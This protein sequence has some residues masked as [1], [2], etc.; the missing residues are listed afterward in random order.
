LAQRSLAG[1]ASDEMAGDEAIA[2]A[3]RLSSCDREASIQHP[4]VAGLLD[5]SCAAALEEMALTQ[6][7]VLLK[8]QESALWLRG[9][10]HMI[11]LQQ[12]QETVWAQLR[13]LASLQDTM[14]QEQ[15][16][17]NSTMLDLASKIDLAVE[18]GE[19]STVGVGASHLLAP[20]GLKLPSSSIDAAVATEDVLVDD[21]LVDCAGQQLLPPLL[22][23]SAIPPSSFGDMSVTS[24]CFHVAGAA[25][26][27]DPEGLRTP[28]RRPG[29]RALAEKKR[30][31]AILSLASALTSQTPP[32]QPQKAASRLSVAAQDEQHLQA[33]K[34]LAK[35][36]AEAPAFV[37]GGEVC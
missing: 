25:A 7:E 13:E 29:R 34:P 23:S 27:D 28:P 2:Q 11:Q 12:D 22:L 19:V 20:P 17:M 35:L 10:E 15:A 14:M 16:E 26:G 30:S 18:N 4:G 9:Q 33:P 1:R 3:S 36:R 6:L 8:E 5:A 31:P 21:I 32:M 24:G 37:P